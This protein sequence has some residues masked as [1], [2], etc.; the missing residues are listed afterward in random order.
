MTEPEK[1]FFDGDLTEAE[2]KIIRQFVKLGD[3]LREHPDPGLHICA[4]ARL[5]GQLEPILT[6]QQKSVL[7]MT[8]AFVARLAQKELDAG[9]QFSSFIAKWKGE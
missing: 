6:P 2:E 9:D 5:A 8:G 1:S 7:W 3:P 4:L